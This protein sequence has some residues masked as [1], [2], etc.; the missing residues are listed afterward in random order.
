M[1]LE[2]AKSSYES[3]RAAF[4]AALVAAFP[5]R[6]EWDWK[7]AVA[8]MRGENI[9]RNDDTSQD[10]AMASH[11]GIRAAWDDYI[12]KLHAFYLLRDGPNGVLGGRGL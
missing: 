10:E 4:H 6:D 11:A 2:Q 8:H 12:T 9:R 1:T 5:G 7:R 3:A